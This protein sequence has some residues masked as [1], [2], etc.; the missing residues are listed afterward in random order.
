[1]PNNR[2]RYRFYTGCESVHFPLPHPITGKISDILSYCEEDVGRPKL[3][4]FE[5]LRLT[6]EGA[7]IV[8]YNERN[9]KYERFVL[10]GQGKRF[11]HETIEWALESWRRRSLHYE[12]RLVGTLQ[13]LRE[14]MEY[15]RTERNTVLREAMELY[16]TDWEIDGGDGQSVIV[17]SPDGFPPLPVRT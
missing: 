14:A 6:H 2:F 11:A 7:W 9:S 16:R 1:M 10:N 5:V 3:D 17:E 13:R 12:R 15:E 8:A 4:R